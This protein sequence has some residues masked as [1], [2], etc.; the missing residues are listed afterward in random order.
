M[1]SDKIFCFL[2]PITM[3]FLSW[4]ESYLGRIYISKYN[5][6]KQ[7]CWGYTPHKFKNKDTKNIFKKNIFHQL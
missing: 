7:I 2:F 6:L 3:F 4:E 5:S 1:L